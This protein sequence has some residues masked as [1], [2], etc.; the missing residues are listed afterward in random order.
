MRIFKQK[1]MMEGQNNSMVPYTDESVDENFGNGNS[2]SYP[3]SRSF[4]A[5]P[6]GRP[7]PGKG[8]SRTRAKSARQ[9]H[10]S[11]IKKL[12]IDYDTCN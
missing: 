8:G 4:S 9:M 10:G 12:E 7:P 6:G 3:K 2:A 1:K 5:K 11:L